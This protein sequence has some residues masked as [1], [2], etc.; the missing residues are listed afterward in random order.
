M[1]VSLVKCEDYKDAA[2]GVKTALAPIGGMGAFVKKGD[3]VL[4]K[5]N[6]LFGKTPEHAVCTHPLFLAA[7]IR[8]VKAA[9]GKPYVGESPG[10]QTLSVAADKSG[11]RAVCVKEQVPLVELDQP[12]EAD[13]NTFKSLSLTARLSDF[14]K[15]IN[16][17]KLKTH[18]FTGYTGAVK[19][20]YG[21]VPGKIKSSYHL[22]FQD[23]QR[24]AEMLLDI[25]DLVQP[26]LTIMDAI[27][28]MEG[29]GPG[30]GNPRRLKT[31]LAS[32]DAIALD[33]VALE[34]IGM[35]PD[36]ALTMK[37]ASGRKSA[38][39]ANIKV[40]GPLQ[41]L[42][43]SDFKRSGTALNKMPVF[44][45]RF[46]QGLFTAK[47]A[48]HPDICIG[49]SQCANI[50][51]AKAIT[52]MESKPHYDYKA[53]IRCYCCHEICPQ[54]AIHLKKGL[55]ASGAERFLR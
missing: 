53:C 25:H 32:P 47:P 44:F 27:V 26:H 23:N 52:M 48:V 51:P 50:C 22:R 55:L 29:H 21:F 24:F 3:T 17:P 12:V 36:E 46:L 1:I 14:Q 20:L 45:R 7:A 8:E 18:M 40:V 33:R 30:A 54:K 41:E 6:I 2:N 11:I 19:N 5:P 34:L 38:D 15:V 39:L 49:C 31:V 28:A 9:G 37:A 4:L 43:V 13:G 35:S 42:K 16:L 10:L